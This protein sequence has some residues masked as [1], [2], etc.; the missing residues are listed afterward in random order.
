MIVMTLNC[1]GLASIPKKLAMRR[2]VDK[3]FIDVLFL[4]ETKCDGVILMGEMESLFKDWKFVSMDPKGKLGG[5]LLGWRTSHFQLL[6]AWAMGSSLCASIYSIELKMALCC[7]NLYGPYV[8]RERFWINLFKMDCLKSSKLIL[9]GDLNFSIGF[10]KIWG[11]K[12]KVDIL[13][14]FSLGR[15]MGLVLW[16]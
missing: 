13:S 4:Q 10:S 3:Q 5:L 15:W 12:A 7:V 11:V 6:N 9:G 16:I 14:Y 2:L 8:D 1:R